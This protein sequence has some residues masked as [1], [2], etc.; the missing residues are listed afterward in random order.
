MGP[1]GCN[2]PLQGMPDVRIVNNPGV[3]GSFVVG[4]GGRNLHTNTGPQAPITEVLRTDVF[5]GL[6]LTLEPGAY[7]AR[8]VGETGL[9]VDQ[10]SGTCHSPPPGA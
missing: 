10:S 5:G 8:F 9:T 1:G 2:P 7:T 6:E 4:T 3:S